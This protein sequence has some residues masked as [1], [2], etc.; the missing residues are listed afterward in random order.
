MDTQTLSVIAAVI[1][2]IVLYFTLRNRRDAR[3]MMDGNQNVAPLMMQKATQTK[4]IRLQEV[5]KTNAR[6][7][8]QLT[9]L[10]A[11]YKSNQLN[12]HDY[13]IKLDKMIFRLDVEL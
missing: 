8:E 2:V 11:A 6:D 12:I 10:I 9:K 7:T 3:K 1:L 4:V 5:T 13:N